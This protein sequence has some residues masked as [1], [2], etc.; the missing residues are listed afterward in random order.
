MNISKKVSSEL[1]KP[2]SKFLMDMLFGISTSG[3]TLIS[4]ISRSL[5]KNIELSYTIERLCNNLSSFDENDIIMNNYFEE[6][7]CQFVDKPVVLFDDSNILKIY[8]GK[9]EDSDYVIDDSSKEKSI[10]SG[11]HVC[12]EVALTKIENN[13]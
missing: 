6:C 8:R 3:S 9:F 10:I 11:Y 13:Q 4:N 12:K 7:R 1:S 5:Q 2:D